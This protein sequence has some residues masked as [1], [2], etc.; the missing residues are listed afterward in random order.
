MRRARC[1]SSFAQRVATVLLFDAVS[2]S[3]AHHNWGLREGI[4][5][6]GRRGTTAFNWAA[7]RVH[8]DFSPT[9]IVAGSTGSLLKD[10]GGR[11]VVISEYTVSVCQNDSVNRMYVVAEYLSKVAEG[12]EFY[13][14]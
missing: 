14:D 5:L 10:A 12:V 1:R 4:V 6:L 13:G 7:N 2:S 3:D 9:I 11:A 8:Q